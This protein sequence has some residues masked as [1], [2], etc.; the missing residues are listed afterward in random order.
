MTKNWIEVPPGTLPQSL[1]AVTNRG[2]L[3]QANLDQLLLTIPG[4]ARFWIERGQPIRVERPTT[5]TDS[6]LELFL[7]GLP[8]ATYYVHRQCL[9]LHAAAL[10]TPKGAILLAGHSATGKST[11]AAAL[12]ARGYPLLADEITPL[13]IQPG[14]RLDVQ[15]VPTCLYL[16]RDALAKLEIAIDDCIQVRPGLARYALSPTCTADTARPLHAIYLLGWTNEPTANL[17]P[18]AGY[19]RF[20]AIQPF[21]FNRLLPES[22][23]MRQQHFMQITA[24]L[25][26]TH[27]HT[28]RRPRDGWSMPSL[29]AAIE[30]NLGF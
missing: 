21:A 15:P 24:S 14:A 9:T 4:Q 18:V 2:V 25:A 12:V 29:V 22:P 23:A 27:I 5:T 26:K 17:T 7:Q 13:A 19:N 3:W 11:L 30:Q 20:L 6:Q 16:W 8:L 10:A 28:L 1:S